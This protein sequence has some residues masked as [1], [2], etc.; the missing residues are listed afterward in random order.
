MLISRTSQHAIKALIYIA[1]QQ[2][3]GMILRREVAERLHVPTAYL[4]KVMQALAKGHL[5]TSLQ[6]PLGGFCLS[7]QPENISLMRVLQI[8]EGAAFT[9]GCVLGLKVCSD[10]TACPMHEKWMPIKEEMISMLKQQTLATLSK[11]VNSG[12]YRINDLPQSL[13]PQHRLGKQKPPD[14]AHAIELSPARLLTIA[15]GV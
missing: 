5:V 3:R 12:E 1:T 9:S 7:E 4:A 2:P 6:G 8:T 13:F 10:K 15:S 11:A 14:R